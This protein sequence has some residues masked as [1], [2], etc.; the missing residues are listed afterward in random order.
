M[1]ADSFEAGNPRE[2]V[3]CLFAVFVAPLPAI[4]DYARIDRIGA[5]Q[6]YAYFKKFLYCLEKFH[7]LLCLLAVFADIVRESIIIFFRLFPFQLVKFRAE[8]FLCYDLA[9]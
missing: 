2:P 9:R 1:V 4:V 3:I 8:L 6:T 7:H 5:F